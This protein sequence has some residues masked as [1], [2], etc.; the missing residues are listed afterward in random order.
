[1]N[2]LKTVRAKTVFA[3]EE[4]TTMLFIWNNKHNV[5]RYQYPWANKLK[6]QLFVKPSFNISNTIVIL[7][8]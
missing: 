7:P 2:F 1:M 6:Y 5:S 4:N 8:R 3:S